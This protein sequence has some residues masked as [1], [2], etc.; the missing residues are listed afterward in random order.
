[1]RTSRRAFVAGS[2]ALG[3]SLAPP[4]AAG[5]SQSGLAQATPKRGQPVGGSAL[6]LTGGVNRGAYQAGAIAGLA[7]KAGIPDGISLPYDLVA[8]SSIGALNAYYVAVAQYGRMRQV[9]RDIAS[10][11]LFTLKRKYR[12]VTDPSSGV[13][14][15]L[16]AAAS[17]AFGMAAHEKGVVDPSAI[18]SLLNQEVDVNSPVHVPLYFTATNLTHRRTEIFVLRGT[19]GDG[20]SRQQRIDALLA[21]RKTPVLHPLN[22]ADVRLALLASAALPVVFDPV[23]VP[24]VDEP[25]KTDEFIDGG[26][27]DNVPISVAKRCVSNIDIIAVDPPAAL[28]EEVEYQNAVEIGAA[29]FGVMQ[30]RI[31]QQSVRLAYAES[32]LASGVASPADELRDEEVPL[33]IRYLRPEKALPGALGDFSDRASLDAMQEIGRADALRGW[34]S[35]SPARVFGQ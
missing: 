25:G 4:A 32:L 6:I 10:L 16:Y 33:Q 7:E 18:E 1:M 3:A 14:S 13:G 30:A 29:V 20:E 24:S 15:R 2:L 17:L 9:W 12:S 27:A 5:A 21:G 26:M 34:L 22:K 31:I 8:G 35:F 23:R 11:P 28:E 19:S